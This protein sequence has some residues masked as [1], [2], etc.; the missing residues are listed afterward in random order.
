MK[1]FEHITCLNNVI[2]HIICNF[3]FFGDSVK[4]YG[5]AKLIYHVFHNLRGCQ[6]CLLTHCPLKM[7]NGY[8]FLSLTLS[9]SLYN[10]M[11]YDHINKMLF[12]F[13]WSCLSEPDHEGGSLGSCLGISFQ[14]GTRFS[15][16]DFNIM[17]MFNIKPITTSR[18]QR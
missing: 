10:L 9:I 12:P 14:K 16:V 18:S 13:D 2:V 4:S 11:L 3:I 8:V 5:M 6:S 17:Y 7:E 15:L 1:T